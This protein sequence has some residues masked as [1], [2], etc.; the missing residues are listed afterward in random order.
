MDDASCLGIE[1]SINSSFVTVPATAA[2]EIPLST[3]QYSED[4]LEPGLKR[5]VE[6]Y[7]PIIKAKLVAAS[8]ASAAARKAAAASKADDFAERDDPPTWMI[9]DRYL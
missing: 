1:D 2:F 7:Y 6:K 8:E 4:D 9:F 5:A 3:A